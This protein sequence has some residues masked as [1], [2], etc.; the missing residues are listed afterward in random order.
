MQGEFKDGVMHGV[1]R[2]TWTDGL[3]YEVMEHEIES[4]RLLT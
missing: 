3:I 1:G 4:T 2:F